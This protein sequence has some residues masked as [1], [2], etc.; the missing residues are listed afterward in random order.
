LRFFVPSA[1]SADVLHL[2]ERQRGV[3][4][5][6]VTAY[7]SGAAPVGSS[8]ISDLLSVRLSPASVRNTLAELSA[9]GLIEKPHASSGRVPTEEGIRHFVDRLLAPSA[10]GQY[11]RRSLDLSFE[12]VQAGH[13]VQLASQVLS[14]HTH[15]LGFVMAPRIERIALQHVSFVRLAADRVLAV[16]LD[17]SGRAHQRVVESPFDER[18]L[19][20]AE[21]DRMAAALNERVVGCNLRELRDLLERDVRSLRNRAGRLLESALQLGLR[22]AEAA[23]ETPTTGDIVIA[24]RLALMDQPEFSDPERLR[25]VFAALEQGERLVEILEELLEGDGV[26]VALGD[27]LELHGLVGCALVVAPYGDSAGMLGVIGPTRMDYG[28]IIPLVSY[29]SQLVTDKLYQ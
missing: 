20:Q 18:N 10:V 19:D 21:L 17:A 4:R 29:C 1:D 11:E 24:T 13:T 2:S 6:L 9:L 25:D 28:R 16:L 12:S 22:A 3:L 8:T 5:A 23:I 14:D 26:S 15:Q 7:V 27:E